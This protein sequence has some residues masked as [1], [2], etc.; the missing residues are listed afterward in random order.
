MLV[1]KRIQVIFDGAVIGMMEVEVRHV[2]ARDEAVARCL[3]LLGL[4][5]CRGREVARRCPP[6]G[7]LHTHIPY[8]CFFAESP[9]ERGGLTYRVVTLPVVGQLSY[10]FDAEHQVAPPVTFREAP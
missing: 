6:A 4:R 7:G 2:E 3:L 8:D 5:P 10:N 1:Q 9:V